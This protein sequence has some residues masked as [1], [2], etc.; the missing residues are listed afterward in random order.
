MTGR[1]ILIVVG[2]ASV[3]LFFVGFGSVALIQY[4]RTVQQQKVAE[5]DLFFSEFTAMRDCYQ[6][7]VQG[8]YS[9]CTVQ[10]HLAQP[11]VFD[12][13]DPTSFVAFAHVGLQ[14]ERV[15]P[16]TSSHRVSVYMQT[17]LHFR[18][19]PVQVA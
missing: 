13:E 7:L 5:A 18:G 19:E 10:N 15:S 11:A 4:Y 1:K 6:K 12:L 8:Y 3:T 14:V 17:I 2:I 9:I 16:F